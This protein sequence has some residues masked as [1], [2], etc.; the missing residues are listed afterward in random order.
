MNAPLCIF[1]WKLAIAF[2]RACPLLFSCSRYFFCLFSSSFCPSLQYSLFAA[3]VS[4]STTATDDAA[5][6]LV[7]AALGRP[8]G[9]TYESFLLHATND[10]PAA[11]SSIAA[12]ALIT[13]LHIF[14]YS[15][16]VFYSCSCI[17][18][19]HTPNASLPHGLALVDMCLDKALAKEKAH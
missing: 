12:F 11:T 15:F 8:L 19:L 2:C 10:K 7:A 4:I 14:F 1:F 6:A 16:S 9:F 3:S 13:I 18:R 17:L 5:P